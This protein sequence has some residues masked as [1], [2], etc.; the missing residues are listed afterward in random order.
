MVGLI[1][2]RGVGT[3]S[4]PLCLSPAMRKN[5]LKVSVIIPVKNGGGRLAEVLRALHRRI[6]VRGLEFARSTDWMCEAERVA[7]YLERIRGGGA[8]I[9]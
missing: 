2:I 1:P 9:S 8:G 3:N 5:P 4:L 6:A 7:G